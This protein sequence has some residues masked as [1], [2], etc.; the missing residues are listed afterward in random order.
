MLRGLA[1]VGVVALASLGSVTLVAAP[2]LAAPPATV[3]TYNYSGDAAQTFTV[4]QGVDRLEY[5]VTGAAGGSGGGTNGGAGGPAHE[6][7]GSLEVTAGQVLDVYVAQPGADGLDAELPSGLP[8][9]GGWGY[10]SGGDGG[11]GSQF[12]RPGG[13]GGGSSAIVIQGQT[14]PAVLGAGGGGGGGRGVVGFC[15]G[16]DGGEGDTNGQPGLAADDC[17][18]PGLGGLTDQG[19]N[20]NGTD[21]GDV[22]LFG[23]GGGGGGAGA[24]GQGGGGGFA[25]A[26]PG[27]PVNLGAGGGGG[28]GGGSLLL[29]VAG[30]IGVAD[31]GSPPA[32]Q[33]SYVQSYETSLAG[34]TIGDPVFGQDATVE[35]TVS[36]LTDSA[37]AVS[38]GTVIASHEGTD[39]ASAPVVGGLSTLVL[40][41]LPAGSTALD[42]TYTPLV[43]SPFEASSGTGSVTVLPAPTEVVLEV[44]GDPEFTHTT[45]SATV[46]P[47]QTGLGVPSGSVELRNA[48]TVLATAELQNGIATFELNRALR[49]GE[50]LLDAAYAGD[51]SFAVSASSDVPVVIAKEV[52]TVSVKAEP[53]P[54][55]A[56]VRVSPVV[57][58]QGNSESAAPT[59]TLSLRVD[60]VTVET[61]DLGEYSGES[62]VVEF[63]GLTL[64][65]GVHNM[66]AVYSGDEFYR[67][68]VSDTYAQ[69]TTAVV[70]PSPNPDPAALPRTGGHST[71]GL[72]VAGLLLGAGGVLLQRTSSLNPRRR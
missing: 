34:A 14:S 31:P 18:I 24:T 45:L 27:V 10:T 53:N 61:I 54:N 4:P 29:D 51:G 36:N 30:S 63:R 8:G 7:N 28:A 32:V 43:N 25:G 48:G 60:G 44:V 67:S 1:A 33:L 52:A 21:G 9:V 56:N 26:H 69:T 11:F 20:G 42:L 70:P 37:V 71:M 59:G 55:A 38:D 2:A 19:L 41:D 50:Y 16:G 68:A 3:V 13:G 64:D 22:I 62:R 35:V 23:G 72:I 6:V 39:L 15:F 65:L 12:S 57:T 49:P 17:L 47:V 58:V 46:S 5:V 66:E 40:A